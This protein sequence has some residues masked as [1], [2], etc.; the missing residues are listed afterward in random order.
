MGG[1]W[2]RELTKPPLRGGRNVRKSTGRC[3]I[4]VWI[5]YVLVCLEF[6]AL[7][8]IRTA[9]Q[10]AH[11]VIARAF[12]LDL[13]TFWPSR[14]KAIN[15]FPKQRFDDYSLGTRRQQNQ[16][17]KSRFDDVLAL[18]PEVDKINPRSPDLMTFWQWLQKSIKSSQEV[19]I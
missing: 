11:L 4:S 16:S 5:E 9:R 2:W 12:G 1:C 14:Q 7:F 18:A 8:S 15:S 10:L 6:A 3:V 17:Q 13:M 19:S